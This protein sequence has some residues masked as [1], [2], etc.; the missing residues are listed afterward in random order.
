MAVGTA[1]AAERR[2]FRTRNHVATA[3][4]IKPSPPTVTPTATPIVVPLLEDDDEP[5]VAA[6]PVFPARA[7]DEVDA[8]VGDP[9]SEVLD[10]ALDEV[11]AEVEDGETPIVVKREGFAGR[12]SVKRGFWESG[13]AAYK[14]N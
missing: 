6:S 5:S 14:Q 12:R 4:A 8:P 13:P 9:V 2:F 3:P 7:G 1:P 10:V 11:E